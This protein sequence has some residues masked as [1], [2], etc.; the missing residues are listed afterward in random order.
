MGNGGQLI[1]VSPS[2]DIVIV[3]AAGLYNSPA[4]N[5]VRE[6]LDAVVD[7]LNHPQLAEATIPS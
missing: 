7:G 1:W 4:Q 2:L 6:V 3:T 5:R